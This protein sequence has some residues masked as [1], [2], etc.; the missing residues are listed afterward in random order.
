[1]CIDVTN[2]KC[3]TEYV[4][5]MSSAKLV[6]FTARVTLGRLGY[7]VLR[8]Y[9]V[10]PLFKVSSCMNFNHNFNFGSHLL[11]KIVVCWRLSSVGDCCLFR[12]F[13]V[14]G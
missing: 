6:A 2:R 10:G 12:L 14:G 11:L 3:T 8:K 5:Q 13:I 1:M 7:I 4:G 9:S